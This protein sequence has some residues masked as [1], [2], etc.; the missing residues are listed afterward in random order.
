MSKAEQRRSNKPIMEKRRRARINHCLN[1]LKSL[2]LDAMNKD[3]ARHSKLEK[4]DIL[5]M[6]VKH[7]QTIQRQQLSLAAGADPTV[8]RRFQSGFTECAGEVG[9]YIGRL[10]GVEAGVKQRLVSHLASCVNGLQQMTGPPSSRPSSEDV[11]NN[12]ASARLQMMT[13][14][15][16][17]P[18]RLPSGELALLLPNSQHLPC[19]PPPLDN[20]VTTTSEP[21]GR[22]SA[23]TAVARSRSPPVSPSSTTMSSYGEESCD[24]P[25]P[26]PEVSST[27][28]HHQEYP[29]R[30]PQNLKEPN[31]FT[32]FNAP[33]Q[34]LTVITSDE[35]LKAFPQR[36]TERK[37]T[38]KDPLDYSVKKDYIPHPVKRPLP[39]ESNL[40]IEATDYQP[41]LKVQKTFRENLPQNNIF[42]ERKSLFEIQ[43]KSHTVITHH[44]NDSSLDRKS[45]FEI[46]NQPST[47][48]SQVSRDMW[49]PW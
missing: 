10:D 22:P 27:S 6:T 41:P 35:M 12:T 4:A 37:P 9:R 31:S 15:Q 30:E 19:F 44:R 24:Q 8:V 5:E 48:S 38:F 36:Y 1:E 32:S 25:F 20:Q 14:L 7:L 16:L 49:R 47:S 46:Q 21:Q 33:I 26:S 13:G 2:I 34:P 17:I 23:F 39:K 29:P 28:E 45:L 43:N 3:P 11:N 18:S 42:E 40:L